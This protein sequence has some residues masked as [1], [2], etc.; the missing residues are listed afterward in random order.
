M[1][2]YEEYIQNWRH[3]IAE[4][5]ALSP[6]D[7]AE[8]EDHLLTDFLQLKEAGLNDQE[9]FWLAEKRLGDTSTICREYEK[10]NRA[11]IWA[12]RM[13]WMIIGYLILGF[14]AFT[15]ITFVNVISLLALIT[16]SALLSAIT[17]IVMETL[18]VSGFVCAGYILLYGGGSHQE[19]SAKLMQALANNPKR[20]TVVALSCFGL[21]YLTNT[22][23]LS[24]IVG[25]YLSTHDINSFSILTH[26]TNILFPF[27]LL[28]LLFISRRK[29][30][31]KQQMA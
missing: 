26:V 31:P 28:S 13:Q 2:R 29:T 30:R 23:L 6:E 3:V 4:D 18:I 15:K 21:F 10:V 25:A 17:Y 24:R 20:V 22:L 19:K 5:E 16:G 1:S 7:L 11:T 9:A 14:F 12:N 27:I 8:L